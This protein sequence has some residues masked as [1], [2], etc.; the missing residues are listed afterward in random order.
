[1]GYYIKKHN[2]LNLI[3]WKSELSWIGI[4]VA[5]YLLANIDDT[6]KST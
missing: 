5:L 2:C 1:M 4:K 3:T 6:E